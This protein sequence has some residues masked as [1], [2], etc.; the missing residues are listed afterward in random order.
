MAITI[1]FTAFMGINGCA[2]RIGDALIDRKR[3]RLAL[4]SEITGVVNRWT[5]RMIKIQ[6][7]WILSQPLWI[8]Q[9]MAGILFGKPSDT[10]GR[11]HSLLHC[12]RRV[13]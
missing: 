10:A 7:D 12:S 2:L 5:P 9:T 1:D 8:C 3:F 6:I 13:I 4:Q 11:L